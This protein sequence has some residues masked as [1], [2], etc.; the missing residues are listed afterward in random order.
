M[1]HRVSRVAAIYDVHGNLPALEAILADFE[2]VNPDLVVVGGDVVAG[3]RPTEVLD[4][5]AQLGEGF[6]RPRQCRSG[7]R[8]SL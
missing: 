4:R 2:N 3:P 6:L 7:G 1:V 5:L 8:R